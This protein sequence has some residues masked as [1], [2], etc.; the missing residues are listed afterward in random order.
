MSLD[1]HTDLTERCNF[2]FVKGG[3]ANYRRL[4]GDLQ[5]DFSK[6]PFEDVVDC[7]FPC[8]VCA[9]GKLKAEVGCGMV[10]GK[11]S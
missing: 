2:A 8:P 6:D 9:L 3:D 11:E 7:I 4:M 10:E 5:W 1:L